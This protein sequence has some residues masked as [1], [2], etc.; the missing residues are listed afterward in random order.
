M[1]K[2]EIAAGVVRSVVQRLLAALAIV[3]AVP[4]AA[5]G[6]NRLNVFLDCEECFE[7]FIRSAVGFVE[8]VRDPAD[9]DVHVIVTLTPTG[10]G[11]RERSL[12]F[13]GAG[14]F[15]GVQHQ[16]KAT[17]EAGDSEDRERRALANAIT[18]GLLN[19]QAAA[20]I[21]QDLSVD[22]RLGQG[23]AAAAPARDRWNHW[24]MSVRGSLS[25]QGEESNREAEL[26]GEVGADR[27]TDAWKITIGTQIEYTREDFDLDEDGAIR[28]SR[29]EREFD[30]LV[31]KSLNDHWSV[32]ALGQIESSSFDNFDAEIYA[33]PAI[34]VNVFPYSAYTR[35]QL[36]A[37]YSI[38]PY[39]AWYGEETL[40]GKL[41]DT[42]GRHEAS[43]TL[44][45]REPWG[46]LQVRFEV[47]SF[48]PEIKQH[49]LDVE[50]EVS[51]RLARG[52]SFTVEGSAS[53][54]RDLI[55]L[56]RRGA[57]AEEVLLRLRRL[58]SGYEYDLQVGLTYTFGSIFNTIVNPRFGS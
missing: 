22:V 25:M 45:Q 36:R 48:L 17:T 14:R 58:Q 12:A 20:G 9:A 35:R 18:I 5:A 11:G 1:V 27:I 24:V 56:P 7:E 32:G 38:G 21:G 29:D 26:S 31:V 8:Y 16:L 46:S 2:G 51:L 42:M 52:L 57:T 54:L 6:Q 4:A 55:S 43:V 49:R 34:E 53:R 39:Q 3:V 23:A 44:D 10:S 40:F 15:A 13:I 33:A 30:W 50:G 28:A 19:Y 47:S 41:E 37:N